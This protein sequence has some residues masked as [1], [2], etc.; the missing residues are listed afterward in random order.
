[1]TFHGQ[2]DHTLDAKNRLNVPA[3]F[4]VAFAGGVVL[5]RGIEPCVE[6]WQPEGFEAFTAS[7]LGDLN[8]ISSERRKLTRYVGRA[9]DTELDS[10]G[11]ITIPQ[12]LLE[13]GGIGREVV[14]IG[15][16]NHLEIWD[17]E[18]WAD[19]EGDLERQIPDI[20]ES[21]GHSS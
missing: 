8:P 1:M 6:V 16:L 4:R 20:A 21:V 2:F 14:V 5:S 9:F 3:R 11:R 19:Y 17:R 12:K 10:A 7:V 18:R 13:H 15:A